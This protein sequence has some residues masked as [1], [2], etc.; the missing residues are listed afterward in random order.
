MLSLRLLTLP[1][2]STVSANRQNTF[3]VSRNVNSKLVN[4]SRPM[5]Y[6]QISRPIMPKQKN[7][8]R[9]QKFYSTQTSTSSNTVKNIHEK[10]FYFAGMALCTSCVTYYL[11]TIENKADNGV[12]YTM[13]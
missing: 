2:L 12:N 6:S 10:W 11:L 13:I 4:Q 5:S 1:K 9:E 8:R 7:Y 3:I